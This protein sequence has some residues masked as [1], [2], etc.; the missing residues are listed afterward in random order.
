MRTDSALLIGGEP[1]RALAVYSV[2]GRGLCV[3]RQAI[4]PTPGTIAGDGPTHDDAV[5]AMRAAGLEPLERVP[6]P[7]GE[8]SREGE[9]PPEL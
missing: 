4:T 1:P 3:T 9:V 5:A 8:V 2:R 7:S 6:P